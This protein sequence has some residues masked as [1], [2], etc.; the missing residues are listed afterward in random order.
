[1][2]KNK[3]RISIEEL[4]LIPLGEGSHSN[5]ENELCVMEAVAWMA[6]EPHSDAPICASGVITDFLVKWNDA[7]PNN[8]YREGL[9]KPLVPKV[10]NTKASQQVEMKRRKMCADWII[11][12]YAPVW[13]NSIGLI[14]HADAV[15]NDPAI[16]NLG[17]AMEAVMAVLWDKPIE[18]GRPYMEGMLATT[19]IDAAYEVTEEWGVPTR[20]AALAMDMVLDIAMVSN[21]LEDSIIISHLQAE[22]VKLVEAMIAVKEEDPI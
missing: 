11:K 22:A 7:L 2:T 19:G 21:P 18:H 1:M 16:E 12:V 14:S 8:A 15:R 10:V 13:L 20:A 3:E 9:L 5:R 17:T 6:G 4:R